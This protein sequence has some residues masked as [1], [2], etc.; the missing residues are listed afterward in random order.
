MAFERFVAQRASQVRAKGDVGS[1]WSQEALLSGAG[2]EA[3]GE[4]TRSFRELYGF[5]AT[6]AWAA[7]QLKDLPPA[8]AWKDGWWRKAAGI[9]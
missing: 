2:W 4:S 3:L 6:L 9:S 1:G 5:P 7:L 8:A